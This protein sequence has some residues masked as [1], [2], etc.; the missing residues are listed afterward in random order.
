[1][2]GK[3]KKKLSWMKARKG[4]SSSPFILK[5]GE[6][7]YAFLIRASLTKLERIYAKTLTNG[8]IEIWFI[9]SF[10]HTGEMKSKRIK[11]KFTKKEFNKLQEHYI[12]EGFEEV[13]LQP[14][15]DFIQSVKVAEGEGWKKYIG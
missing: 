15:K 5:H 8:K 12:G 6:E 11:K 13:E 9:D 2:S 7:I 14:I 3:T 10:A 4:K 1:M